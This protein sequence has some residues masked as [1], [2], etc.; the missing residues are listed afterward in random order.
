L[1]VARVKSAKRF[2]IGRIVEQ[3]ALDAVNLSEPEMRAL[4]FA[5][6]TATKDDVAAAE[7]FDAASDTESF[8]AKIARLLHRAYESDA[9]SGDTMKWYRS[10]Q[11]IAD[12][13]VYLG[14]MV[15]RAE[16]GTL[17]PLTLSMRVKLFLSLT[18]LYL[19]AAAGAFLAFT[20]FGARLVPGN[21]LRLTLSVLIVVAP[22]VFDKAR[23]RRP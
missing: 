10:M 12:E 19:C 3:A 18:S 1:S 13:D 7:E 2:L 9:K 17:P 11:S 22:L 8:E 14:V 21:L 23:R 15:S 20:Q 16:I 5:E 6:L 4:D